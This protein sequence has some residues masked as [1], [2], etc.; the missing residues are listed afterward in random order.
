MGKWYGWM[1]YLLS[2][3]QLVYEKE[4]YLFQPAVIDFQIENYCYIAIYTNMALC[5]MGEMDIECS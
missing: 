2:V 5:E 3:R 4:H 1:G